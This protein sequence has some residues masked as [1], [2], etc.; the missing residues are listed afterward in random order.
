[1]IRPPSENEI[2]PASN[3]ASRWAASRSKQQFAAVRMLFDWLVVGQIVWT[4]VVLMERHW[5]IRRPS[6]RTVLGL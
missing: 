5:V 3:A 2:R 1:M 6:S 4:C